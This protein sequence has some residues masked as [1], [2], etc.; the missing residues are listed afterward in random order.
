MLGDL[1]GLGSFIA[2]RSLRIVDC[3]LTHE[4]TDKCNDTLLR[5]A[6]VGNKIVGPFLPMNQ[7]DLLGNH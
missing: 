6:L 3:R 1:E 5:N 2:D 4:A 7:S